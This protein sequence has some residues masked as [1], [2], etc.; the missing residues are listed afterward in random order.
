M[1]IN[2][3]TLDVGAAV[4]FRAYH[5]SDNHICLADGRDDE[6]KNELAKRRESSFAGRGGRSTTE[7]AAELIGKARTENTLLLHTGDLI[8]FVSRANLEYAAGCFDGCDTLMCAGNH[9]F[10]LYVGEAWEDEAYKAQSLADVKAAL[11]EGI[12]FGTREINGVRFIT[13]DNSYYYILPELY[14]KTE[15]ALADGRPC[16]LLVHTPL[17]SKD[18]YG[19]VMRGKSA[20][21]PPYLCGC[22]EELLAGLSEHRRRQQHADE[23]TLRFIRLCSESEN[24]KAVLTGHI[25]EPCFSHLDGGIPQIAADGAYNGVMNEYL[26]I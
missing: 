23:T 2:R 18:T 11:P 25:H 17:Y 14:K 9:E 21:E 1:K 19:K 26:F 6:C 4:P 3:Y 7:T 16:V 5:M 10:S 12:R 22:P 24:L 20:D 8:D 13:L 15:A